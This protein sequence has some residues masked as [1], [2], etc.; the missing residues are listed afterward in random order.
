M[1]STVALGRIGL[2]IRLTNGSGVRIRQHVKE[3][4]NMKLVVQVTPE[5]AKE[6]REQ[7]Y[8][9][10]ATKELI[11]ATQ[12]MGVMLEPMHPDVND[13]LALYFSVSAEDAETAQRIAERLRN[14]KA[15]DAAYL[16]P[17][18]SLP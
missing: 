3:G 18:E 6:I 9:N 8:D 12:D 11:G 14:L 4:P 7:H 15:V 13:E 10:K 1:D 16:K 2:R 17:P 5:A